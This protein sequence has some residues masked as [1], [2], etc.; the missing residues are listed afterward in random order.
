M[1]PVLLEL[2]FL[3][4]AGDEIQAPT[5]VVQSSKDRPSKARRRSSEK[6]IN[7]YA[8]DRSTISDD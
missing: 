8:N 3:V 2:F 1:L 5:A 7:V 4:Y 6:L